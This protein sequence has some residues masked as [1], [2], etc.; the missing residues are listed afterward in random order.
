MLREVAVNDLGD[1]ALEVL[2]G[3][4]ALWVTVRVETD[5]ATV[6]HPASSSVRTTLL[7]DRRQQ[8]AISEQLSQHEQRSIVFITGYG[9]A[10]HALTAVIYL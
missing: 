3:L 8:V 10:S 7:P 1:A 2:E 9:R 6:A 4:I 5:D